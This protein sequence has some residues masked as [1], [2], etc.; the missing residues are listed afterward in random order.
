MVFLPYTSKQLQFASRVDVIWDVYKAGSLKSQ[1][2]ASRGSGELLRVATNTKLY[3]NCKTFIRVDSN[4]SGPFHFLADA[5]KNSTPPLNKQLVTTREEKVLSMPQC[6]L[7]QLK[8]CTH[9]EADGR[10]LLNAAHAYGQGHR[11]I[12][13]QA[14]DTD[15]VVIVIATTNIL[16][17]CKFWIAFSYGKRFRYVAVHI[18]ANS[19]GASCSQGL[20]FLHAFSGC[21]TVSLFYGIAKIS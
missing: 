7:I 12:I 11:K 8:S 1:V 4:I 10:L 18:I 20:L 19:L 2:R 15:V 5:M 13:I 3:R 17:G 6:E 9:E 21:D 14:S 16:H